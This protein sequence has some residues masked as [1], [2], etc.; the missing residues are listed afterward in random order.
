MSA[1]DAVGHSPAE[2]L[3]LGR[4]NVQVR[5]HDQGP[6]PRQAG[7]H[8]AAELDRLLEAPGSKR[9]HGVRNVLTYVMR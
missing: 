2:G 5:V 8:A 6:G 7:N 1:D 4:Q 3:A 9:V